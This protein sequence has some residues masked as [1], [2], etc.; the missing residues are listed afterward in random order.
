MELTF[1]L[2]RRFYSAQARN[3]PWFRELFSNEHRTFSRM[4]I[5]CFDYYLFS[6]L[7]TN[8][9]PTGNICFGARE[10]V[11]DFTETQLGMK[12]F[13]GRIRCFGWGK[14]RPDAPQCSSLSTQE[15]RFLS[16]FI[17][18]SQPGHSWSHWL[19]QFLQW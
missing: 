19:P 6:V 11:G 18:R 2:F 1:S 13:R 12:Q 10:V 5:I 8:S 14:P 9:M 3:T 7:S 16:H 17:P 4:P 15:S